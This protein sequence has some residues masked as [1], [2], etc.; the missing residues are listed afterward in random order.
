MRK[1]F[2]PVWILILAAGLA[3]CKPTPTPTLLPTAT[4]S[5]TST[6]SA[7]PTRTPTQHPTYPLTSSRT[8]SPTPLAACPG[9]PPLTLQLGDWAIVSLDPP[10]PNKVRSQAGV[11]GELIGQI[12]PGE[13]VQ[14]L[15][16]PTCAD[17][18]AW[19][20]VRSL[21][22][23]EGWT[24]EG[25]AAGYWLVDPISV[26]STMPAPLQSQATQ[27]HSLRELDLAPDTVFASSVTGQYYPLAT[28]LPTPL[29]EQT[30]E[31]D[32]PRGSYA[33]GIQTHSAHSEYRFSGVLD[34]YIT[35]YELQE[36]LSRYYL[37]DLSYDDCTRTL[38]RN[39]D[40]P[41]V[42]A[43]YLNPFCGVRADIPLHFKVGLKRIDF[44]GG[45]GVRFLISSA[46]YLTVNKLVYVFEG[47][48]EDGRYYI[49]AH[50]PGILHP[51]IVDAVTLQ[52]DFGPLLG[53]KKGQYE[54]ASASYQ[55]FNTRIEQMLEAGALP[56]Y[57]NLYFLDTMLES[58][59][60]K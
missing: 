52:N 8:P 12:Q 2:F 49:R 25:D 35:V 45:S 7:S 40:L 42:T 19:W 11:S 59:V 6:P 18:Y 28:P 48:S 36:P 10:L 14:V 60:M 9:A 21:A 15:E 37:N 34:G 43:A 51:Y 46:N 53:W 26:W 5:A 54:A 29:T 38:R 30:P 27:I 50:F 31:P 56:L 1:L 20:R 13:N 24:V 17:G 16:G 3:A 32:D 22:G 33:M 39:L 4:P 57:P 23:L 44:N 55:R 47:L 41:Q 58:I